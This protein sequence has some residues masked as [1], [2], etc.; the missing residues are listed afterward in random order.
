M[1]VAV[2]N[3]LG[4]LE[5]V[6]R[7]GTGWM[8]RCPAHEDRN[9][10]LA[11]SEGEGGRA[12]LYCHAGCQTAA[13][14]AAL[15]LSEGDLFEARNGASSPEIVATYPYVDEAGELLF[16]AV[17]YEPKDF[18]QRRPDGIGGWIWNLKD[19]RRVL[20]R[21]PAV[22]A[23]VEAGEP[24]VVVEGEKDVEALERAGVVAT[25]NPMGAGK[26]R[27]E[28]AETLRG[29]D[30]IVVP[31]LDREGLRHALDVVRSLEGKAASVE[32]RAPMEEKDVSDHLAAGYD[33]ADLEPWGIED[34]ER[35]AD[36]AAAEDE[37]PFEAGTPPA[38]LPDRGLDDIGNA[39]RFADEHHE[40]LRYCAAWARWLAWDGS[41]WADDDSLEALRRAKQTSRA[42]AE[43]A[44]AE[45]DEQ[46][47]KD[48][49]GHA[50]RSAGEPRLRSMLALAAS[51]LRIVVRPAELDADPWLLNTENGTVDLRSG[52]LHPHRPEEHLTMLAGAAYD[53]EAQ[54]PLWQAHLRR[55]L[56]DDELIAFLQRLAGL[57]AIGLV[58]EHLLAMLV[59]GGQNGK[60]VTMDAIAAALGDYA[61][62]STA[63]LLLQGR[64]GVGQATPEIADLRGRRY[65][66]VSETPEDARLAAERVK[67]ITGG[68]T[69]TARRLHGNPFSFRPSHTLWLGTNHKPRIADDSPAIWRRV[70]LI[71]F[72]VTIPESER[73]LKIGEKLAAERPGLL[74][75]IVDGARAYLSDGLKPP[76]AVTAATDRYRTEED[77]FKAFLEERTIAEKDASAP[78]A[79]LLKAYTA[80]AS[81]NGWPTLSTVALADKLERA[82]S[83]RKRTK[84]G[85]RWHGLRLRNGETLDV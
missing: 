21:L 53:P 70:L 64:R 13:I 81:E 52:E 67:W 63:S 46:R 24:V 32:I 22:L 43:E 38:A 56:V 59:G 75:W 47:R 54:A 73:D 19:V 4:R 60:T 23:A 80:W 48:L 49:L 30:V 41:R 6:K 2:E 11:I 82:G 71:P 16:E 26:W 40:G 29:A 85:A 51:D 31:D 36:E 10:S 78:A 17:R 44:A 62:A 42:L 7:N 5:R 1:S 45:A 50:R 28:Y 8:A 69:I 34:L 3:V 57:S 76:P 58:R 79:A 55:C 72:T 18:R 39:S 9:P 74:R 14:L 25:C 20:Y 68:D 66:T 37:Q 33:L 84:T 35:Q 27:T 77:F 83:V 12:L 61:A 15:G 65:V